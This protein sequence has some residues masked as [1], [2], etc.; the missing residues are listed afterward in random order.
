MATRLPPHAR[1]LALVLTAATDPRPQ[2]FGVS[3]TGA[4]TNAQ[5][6]LTG[7]PLQGALVTFDPTHGNFAVTGCY[8]MD[9]HYSTA[10]GNPISNDNGPH[11]GNSRGNYTA[12]LDWDG[13]QLKL[14]KITAS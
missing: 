13:H 1:Q 11:T 14:L 7:D 9:L 10:N 3:Q 6:T 4:V 8:T 12:T 5:W 2:L